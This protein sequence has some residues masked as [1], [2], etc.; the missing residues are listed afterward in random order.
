MTELTE[1]PQND[2][3][4][5]VASTCTG[6]TPGQSEHQGGQLHETAAADHRVDEA[7]GEAGQREQQQD[8]GAGVGHPA[9]LGGADQPL[10]LGVERG[11]LAR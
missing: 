7:G 5:L 6:A 9:T 10:P 11:G 1:V 8:L 3:S 4:L 2:A